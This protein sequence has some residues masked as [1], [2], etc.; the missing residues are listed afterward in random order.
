MAA[1]PENRNEAEAGGAERVFNWDRSWLFLG[2]VIPAEKLHRDVAQSMIYCTTSRFVEIY[3]KDSGS[4]NSLL[5]FLDG[6]IAQIDRVL[7]LNLDVHMNLTEVLDLQPA[8]NGQC[9]SLFLYTSHVISF[10]FFLSHPSLFIHSCRSLCST[11]NTGQRYVCYVSRH[12]FRSTRASIWTT[13]MANG[14]P[15]ICDH[16]SGFGRVRSFVA[17]DGTSF[18]LMSRRINEK[19]FEPVDCF[20]WKWERIQ[21]TANSLKSNSKFEK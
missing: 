13:S 4:G 11:C 8:R 18:G 1:P 9:S 17:R 16:Q 21:F 6:H 20:Q 3:L 15:F 2:N 12:V 19:H 10:P 7:E 5:E 14:A